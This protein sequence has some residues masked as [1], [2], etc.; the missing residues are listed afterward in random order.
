VGLV[1][2]SAGTTDRN[3]QQPPCI[4]SSDA[5]KEGSRNHANISCALEALYHQAVATGIDQSKTWAQSI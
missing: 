2:R 1:L 4:T 3:N 5:A